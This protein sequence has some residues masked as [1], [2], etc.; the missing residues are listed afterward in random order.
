MEKC[1]IKLGKL[2]KQAKE[3]RKEGA[4]FRPPKTTEDCKRVQTCVPG[5]TGKD[6]QL[7]AV[8]KPQ[9]QLHEKGDS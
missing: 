9:R 4:Q 3:K 7:S 2:E 5:K 6:H 8:E 1:R